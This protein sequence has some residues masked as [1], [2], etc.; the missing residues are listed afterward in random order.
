[1]A[2]RVPFGQPK[3]LAESGAQVD[4]Q[5]SVAKSGLSGPDPGQQLPA[6]LVQLAHMTPPEALLESHQRRWRLDHTDD[7]VS[8]RASAQHVVVVN[9]VTIKVGILAPTLA[10]P[11]TRP[12]QYG[13][14]PTRPV[15]DGGPGSPAR[16]AQHC[17][18]GGGHRRRFGCDWGRR[19][20]A[21]VGC[22]S[23]QGGFPWS[24]IIIPE[25]RE[26][27]LIPLPRRHTHL[28]GGLGLMCSASVT[29]DDW[30]GQYDDAIQL[31]VEL[32]GQQ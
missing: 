1:M 7:G 24:K 6:H 23:F 21:S 19:V 10:R 3:G 18:P 32:A 30:L 31:D 4:G 26:H 28:F 11:R 16:T 9:A 8:R 12:W 29:R 14:S 27:V 2:L 22:S 20:V 17:P 13:G 25:A 5:R 15:P